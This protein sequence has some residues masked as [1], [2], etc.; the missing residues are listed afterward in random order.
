M[1][2]NRKEEEDKAEDKGRNERRVDI[3]F[4]LFPPSRFPFLFSLLSRL[5]EPPITSI[6]NVY[7]YNWTRLDIERERSCSF[8]LLALFLS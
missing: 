4:F 7:K 2:E 5:L 1:I 8:A 3:F 6:Y